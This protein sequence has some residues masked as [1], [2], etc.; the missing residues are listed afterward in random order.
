MRRCFGAP[1]FG[2]HLMSFRARRG[3]IWLKTEEGILATFVSSRPSTAFMGNSNTLEVHELATEEVNCQISEIISAGHAV[4]FSP[5]T[6]AQANKEGYDTCAW[7][8]G[9]STR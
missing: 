2:K 9:G 8:L 4:I 5:D 6:K 1:R 7:C 3:L